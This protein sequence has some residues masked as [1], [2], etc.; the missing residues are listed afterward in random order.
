MPS[1]FPHSG[2]PHD[3][4]HQADN[5]RRPVRAQAHRH[6]ALARLLSLSARRI[7]DRLEIE[8][9]D[10]GGADNGRLPVTY[11]DFQKYGLH[12]Q[13]IY[14]AIRETVALGFVEI[15]E[16][17]V[18]GNAE[19]RKPNKFRITYRA[20]NGVLGDGS[21]EWRRIGDDDAQHIA[22]QARREKPIQKQNLKYGSRQ[23][24]VPKPYRKRQIHSTET[25][26]TSDSTETTTTL[27]IS[28]V[29]RP[30]KAREARPPKGRRSERAG[31][32]RRSFRPGSGPYRSPI[33]L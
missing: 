19:F 32:R 5:H 31:V 27:D 15:T 30:R 9:A 11:D 21:H 24:S 2:G 25:T 1:A 13:A 17:G 7:L 29:L 3:R 20:A 12:R 10:H 14:P 4:A 16:Q 23:K 22:A 28:S 33:W 8:L 18:A 26:T 6:A